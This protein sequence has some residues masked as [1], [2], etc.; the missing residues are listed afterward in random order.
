M[1]TGN[2]GSGDVSAL[3][4]QGFKA[5]KE[6]RRDE[7]Y[8][9]F[10]E[11][12][13][14]DPN[15]E[16]GWLYRA[17]TTDDLSESYVCLRRVLDINPNNEKAQRGIERIQNRVGNDEAA[18]ANEDVVSG[19]N[20]P[21]RA[22]PPPPPPSL[23]LGQD[24]DNFGFE[25][26]AGRPSA[27]DIPDVP[28]SVPPP[29]QGDAE[30]GRFAD[31]D[32]GQA[33]QQPS[34]GQPAFD[35]DFQGGAEQG[36]QQYD[37]F[38]LPPEAGAAGQRQN[39]YAIPNF[40]EQQDYVNEPI[41]D[42][43]QLRTKD[44]LR[45]GR[46]QVPQTTT[47]RRVGGGLAPV[48]GTLANARQRG[49]TAFGSERATSLDNVGRRQAQQR[50]TVLYMLGGFLLLIAIVIFIALLVLGKNESP[51]Q[52][53]A[54]ATATADA[55]AALSGANTPGGAGTVPVAGI[56]TPTAVSNPVA[57]PIVTQPVQ[58]TAAVPPTAVVTQTQAVQPTATPQ[59]QTGTPRPRAVVYSVKAGD[60][61]TAIARQFNTTVDAIRAANPAVRNTSN[62]FRGQQFVVPVQ[63]G[64][65]R[66][67]E[68]VI[69][70]DG[71]N[72]QALAGRYNVDVNEL[73]R[74]NGFGSPADAKP[75]DGILIP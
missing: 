22:V 16:L 25:Q 38:N 27:R 19:F 59:P 54:A 49:K 39:E 21:G 67:R 40:D 43:A 55:N 29:Y 26:P 53:A 62:I 31:D 70:K 14:R 20:N 6:N 30:M 50:L 13:R 64:D 1:T 47:G 48:F 66:G 46:A 36:Y 28:Q 58:T 5:A 9:I 60:N 56:D 11:V 7:A 45:S 63:R 32:F 37:D 52:Q 65:Y 57:T 41:Q 42:T 61:L 3:L 10:C 71:E 2:T 18:A 75:G 15:N 44:R 34:F 74:F 33:Y 23:N 69:L 51:E 8:N 17:A 73:A 12:V 72:L 68:G 24:V 35:Q 4:V